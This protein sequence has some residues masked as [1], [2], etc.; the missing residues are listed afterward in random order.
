MMTIQ[1]VANSEHREKLNRILCQ[2]CWII[3][4]IRGHGP[5]ALGIM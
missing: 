2:E 4:H 5:I 3:I 1:N